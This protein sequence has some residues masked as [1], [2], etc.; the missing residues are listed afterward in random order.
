MFLGLVTLIVA[1]DDRLIVNTSL[2]SM[3]N[4]TNE[5]PFVIWDAFEIGHESNFYGKRV[6]T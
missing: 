4:F 6:S 2:T 3:T 5:P 1:E